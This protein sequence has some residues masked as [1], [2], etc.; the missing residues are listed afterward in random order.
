M[1]SLLVLFTGPCL[2]AVGQM[3]LWNAGRADS[4]SENGLSCGLVALDLEMQEHIPSETSVLQNFKKMA[5]H[6]WG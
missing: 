1:T 3:L 2:L 5:E 4:T 6:F